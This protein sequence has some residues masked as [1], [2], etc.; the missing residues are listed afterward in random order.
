[1]LFKYLLSSLRNRIRNTFY[2]LS[3]KTSLHRIRIHKNAP[4]VD[5]QIQR[6]VNI[7]LLE[8]EIHRRGWETKV[9]MIGTRGA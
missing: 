7:N 9:I 4:Q 1:M 5:I 3:V 6:S 8:I 2:G